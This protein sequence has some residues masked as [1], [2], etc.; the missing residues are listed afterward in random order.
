MRRRGGVLAT[1]CMDG[2]LEGADD[3][4]ISSFRITYTHKR[5]SVR[6]RRTRVRARGEKRGKKHVKR[7]VGKERSFRKKSTQGMHRGTASQYTG[8]HMGT[9]MVHRGT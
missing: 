4:R 1:F 5:I 6:C 3:G 2:A 9:H 8:V 7:S